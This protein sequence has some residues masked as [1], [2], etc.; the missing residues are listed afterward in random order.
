MRTIALGKTR[1]S[2]IFH[3]FLA[4]KMYQNRQCKKVCP[5]IS[6]YDFVTCT[7]AHFRDFAHFQLFATLHTFNFSRLC[8]LST[9]QQL[10]NGS[11]GTTMCNWENKFNIGY[12]I[13]NLKDFYR[14]SPG[15]TFNQEYLVR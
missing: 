12:L 15:G 5:S 4:G 7:L 13:I 6:D 9:L 2:D 10:C 1:I 14:T 3:A 8:T 11:M